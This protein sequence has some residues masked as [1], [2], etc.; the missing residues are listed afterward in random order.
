MTAPTMRA[1]RFDEYGPPS[2]LRVDT[3]DVPEPKPAQV[4]IKVLATAVHPWDT[5]LR[6]GLLAALVPVT[7]PHT[8]GI[9]FAGEVVAVGSAV[10]DAPKIGDAVYGRGSR[11]FAEYM[12]ANPDTLAPMPATLDAIQAAAVPVG[13]ATAWS[14]LFDA[15]A[16]DVGQ[17]VLI[18]GAAGG[19]GVFATQ[20][21]RWRGAHV[22]ATTSAANRDF[23]LGLGAAE[24]VDYTTTAFEDV[25]SD[26]DAVID[27]VGGD[28]IARSWSVLRRG[29]V[30]VSIAGQPDPDAAATHGVRTVAVESRADTTR[31]TEVARLI[32]SGAIAVEVAAVFAMQDIA[33]AHV[34]SETGHGRG[35]IV[36][37]I[38]SGD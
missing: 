28:G 22:I 17:R 25:V 34:Q 5:K 3:V 11:T 37:D 8:P 20:L 12:T 33:A 23:V 10:S 19:V 2:V 36:V 6:R 27:L 31:L 32:D 18:L 26:V 30:L 38:R 13:V 21:A 15:A 1:V 35:R 4:L 14:A 24:V 29:G 9:D 7:F 16:I